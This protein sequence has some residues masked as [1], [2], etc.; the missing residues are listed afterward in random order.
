MTRCESLFDSYVVLDPTFANLP[1]G[2]SQEGIIVFLGDGSGNVL[3]FSW[4]SRRLKRV[5]KSTLAA[6]TLVLVEAAETSFWLTRIINEILNADVPIIC[7]ADNHSLF[8]AA[9]SSKAV[10]DKRLR[11]GIAIVREMVQR[12][13]ASVKWIEWKYQL[14]DSLTKGVL[15][16]QSC[17]IP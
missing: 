13:E 1:Y 5:V 3:P 15:T 10:E 7:H 9:Y 12:K 2:G 4:S 6:E 8:E 17:L 14:A 11:L 16:A